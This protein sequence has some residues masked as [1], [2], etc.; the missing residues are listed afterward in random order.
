MK[1]KI[2]Y[3][4]SNGAETIAH[5][6]PIEKDRFDL[7]AGAIDEKPPVFDAETQTCHFSDGQWVVADIVQPEIRPK[8]KPLSAIERLRHEQQARL[9][10]TEI[11]RWGLMDRPFTKEVLAYRQSIRDLTQTAT[12]TIDADGNLQG[13]EF[14]AKLAGLGGDAFQAAISA[15]KQEYPK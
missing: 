10:E 5:E 6:D 9:R 8:A 15:V 14:P 1:T 4:M 12:P 13:V 7:P 11:N 2:V 3:I